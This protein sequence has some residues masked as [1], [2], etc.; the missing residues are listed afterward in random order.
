M[1]K[2]DAIIV[3]G[4]GIHNDG[5]LPSQVKK[6]VEKAALLYHKGLA[7]RV[8]MTGKWSFL[9]KGRPKR[10]EARAMVSYAETLKIPKK[11]LIAEE[12]STDT[13][14]NAHFTKKILEKRKWKNVIIVT[15]DFHRQRAKWIFH[16][17]LGKQ[18]SLRLVTVPSGITGFQLFET[19][20][21]EKIVLDFTKNWLKQ[22]ARGNDRL[23]ENLL[24]AEHP[25]YSKH[26]KVTIKELE[27]LAGIH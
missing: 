1:Q 5:S 25:G 4:G 17:V 14:G 6:R 18:F 9:H 2:A 10:T 24:L 16:Q 22:V 15:S 21:K 3:L 20:E 13:I 11:A 23:L 19:K 26:P 8:I 12:R 27:A 7:K